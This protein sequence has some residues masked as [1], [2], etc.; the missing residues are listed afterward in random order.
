MELWQ[1][2]QRQS[3][4]LEAK[5]I[6]TQNVIRQWYEHYDGQ[7]YVSFS[8][9]KDST[10]LL[11]LV[12]ELYPEVPAVFDDTGLEYPE[13]KDFVKTI[14]NVIT[15]KPSMPFNQVIEHYGYPVLSK[16]QA[17]QIYRC[18]VT[19][20]PHIKKKY[21]EGI[22]PDG[23][24]TLF[25]L[26]KL[27]KKLYY[28]DFKI[29]AEC[30]GIMKKAPFKKFEKKTGLKQISGMLA[31]EGILRQQSYLRTGCNAFD[32][33]R[34]RSMP[35]AIWTEQDI[36]RY[37]VQFKLSYSKI[38]GEILKVVD[39]KEGTN[40]SLFDEPHYKYITTGA[41]RT[42]CMFCMFGVHMEKEPNRFQ[43]MKLTHPKQ[44]DYCINKL[45][46]GQVLD[47]IGVKY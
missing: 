18:R 21:L 46:L 31:D 10:V 23:T 38:Y 28:S 20:L 29:S 33:L 11:S 2:K 7:V 26:T 44:Y 22:N 12:R 47:Y 3:L 16:E 1:L 24:S 37:I 32:N 39:L 13:I 30:C 36:L 4:P 17:N 8:G 14:D 15:I 40:F 9:G 43:R 25:K 19:K 45:G 35:L 42:G 27:G 6:H 41:E 5:I 34:P